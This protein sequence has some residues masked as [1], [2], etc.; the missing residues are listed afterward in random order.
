M[1]LDLKSGHMVHTLISEHEMILGFLDEL[2]KTN[3]SV[4]KMENYDKEKEEFKK[5]K[6]IAEHLVGA[7]PHHKREEDVLFPEIERRGVLG[8]TEVMR[9]EHQDLRKNKKELKNLAETAEKDNFND[10]KKK[11]DAVAKNIVSVLSE[12]I[13][14][15]N[16]ILYPA[17][18][19]VISD[20]KTWQIMKNGCDKIGY[21]CF[22][23]TP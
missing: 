2:E 18:L 10:F 11:L 14:K 22:T 16:N 3:Q 17:A 9:M 23:P 7:E 4:Q 8:P 15:E 20:E 6:N 21:C 1:L 19:E 12:H 5:L 13:S